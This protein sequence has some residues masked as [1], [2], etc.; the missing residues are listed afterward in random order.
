M[1]ILAFAVAMKRRPSSAPL[2]R[3]R[4][5]GSSST[6]A[7]PSRP[8]L[9][10]VDAYQVGQ[11]P[12]KQISGAYSMRSLSGFVAVPYTDPTSFTTAYRPLLPLPAHLTLAGWEICKIPSGH[13]ILFNNNNGYATWHRP[14]ESVR[15][16]Q[17]GEHGFLFATLDPARVPSPSA[18][19]G[20][21]RACRRPPVL[22]RHLVKKGWSHVCVKTLVSV[23]QESLGSDATFWMFRTPQGL[24]VDEEGFHMQKY[25]NIQRDRVANAIRSMQLLHWSACVDGQC[26]SALLRRTI[27]QV[28]EPGV[29]STA[30]IAKI[31]SMKKPMQEFDDNLSRNCADKII[32][33]LHS[34]GHWPRTMSAN[35]YNLFKTTCVAMEAGVFNTA[36]LA[37]IQAMKST[38]EAEVRS[39]I[40]KPLKFLQNVSADEIM[41]KIRA[42][43]YIPRREGEH[44]LL[45]QQYQR[46][47]KGGRISQ[48]QKQEA[49][50]LTAAH[51]RLQAET[52]A[53]TIMKR[54]RALG[55]WPM[56]NCRLAKQICQAMD[57]GIFSIAQTAE[58]EAMKN[59]DEARK[60]T[61]KDELA[62]KGASK[63]LEQIRVLGYIP[64]YRSEHSGL[65]RKYQQAVKNGKISALDDEFQ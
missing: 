23:Q 49:E 12:E 37:E 63:I 47:V 26:S 32:D 60:K 54:L 31:K 6:R 3:K 11:C 43:G 48:S 52:H 15:W 1:S 10:P 36:Q 44:D 20:A 8:S 45:A 61:R 59:E 24:L 42:L 19:P 38:M 53:E 65:A 27:L 55:H 39:N 29:F 18:L 7:W 51:Q 57:A 50:A 40:I 64:K 22:P 4:P 56:R 28:I 33:E 13:P 62:S 30:Q 2:V 5:A 34:L 16:M 46:A 9:P 17:D 58:I 41:Q 21:P 35:E 25:E 14:D